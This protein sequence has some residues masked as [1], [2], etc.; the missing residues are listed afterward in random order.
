MSNPAKI[1]LA[2]MRCSG[3]SDAKTLAADLDIPIRTIQRLKLECATCAND[4]I[5]DAAKDANC[6]IYGVSEAPNAPYMALSRADSINNITTTL[7]VKEK[8]SS[9]EEPK[10]AKPPKTNLGRGEALQAFEA[11]NDMAL[12]CGLPQAS[13]MTPD[14]ERK[15]VARLKDYGLD[16]WHT[17]IA[18]VEKSPFLTG[19]NERGWR[20]SLD[21][22][23]QPN[24]FSKTHDG[25]YGDGRKAQPMKSTV[26]EFRPHPQPMKTISE[27]DLHA[28]V[29]ADEAMADGVRVHG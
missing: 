27:A 7:E 8:G 9:N 1:L 15:I 14:R 3:I 23:L 28:L 2:Y 22:L 11:Y 13:K 25:G 21:F 19:Q 26:V 10:K 4:A 5:S 29:L 24:S 6:A 18:N 17:A 12:R 20:A 16:G